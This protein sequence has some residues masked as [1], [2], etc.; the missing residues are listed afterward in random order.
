MAL[1]SCQQKNRK[2][3]NNLRNVVSVS[4]LPSSSVDVL[5]VASQ[6]QAYETSGLTRYVNL[7][8][9][10]AREIEKNREHRVKGNELYDSFYFSHMCSTGCD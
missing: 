10:V 2:Q 5:D 3:E 6:A 4:M 1:S 8:S 7:C 9:N